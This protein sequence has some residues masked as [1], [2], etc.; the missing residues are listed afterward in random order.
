MLGF[1]QCLLLSLDLG[2]QTQVTTKLLALEKFNCDRKIGT[3][4]ASKQTVY[5]VRG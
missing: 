4:N 2:T 3:N 1:P 5:C